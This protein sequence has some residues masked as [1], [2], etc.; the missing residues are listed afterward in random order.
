[1]TKKKKKIYDKKSTRLQEKWKI[2]VQKGD[3]WRL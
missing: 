1:M 2:G 3:N